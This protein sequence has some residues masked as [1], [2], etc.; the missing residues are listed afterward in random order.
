MSSEINKRPVLMAI[1]NE[2]RRATAQGIIDATINRIHVNLEKI[3][4]PPGNKDRHFDFERIINENVCLLLV[5]GI[6]LI[7]RGRWKRV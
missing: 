6:G 4:L 7:V 5:G 3:P 2:N 1:K